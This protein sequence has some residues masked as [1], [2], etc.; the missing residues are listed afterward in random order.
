VHITLGK[1]FGKHPHG[2]PKKGWED[3]IQIGFWKVRYEDEN[4]KSGL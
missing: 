4:G 1:P 3:N 2:W